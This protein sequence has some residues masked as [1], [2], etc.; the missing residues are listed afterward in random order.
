MRRAPILAEK[1]AR[2]VFAAAL[3]VLCSGCGKPGIPL[4]EVNG[5]VIDAA[6]S[7]PLPGAKVLVA[8]EGEVDV[9]VDSQVVR[10]RQCRTVTGADG[11]FRVAAWRAPRNVIGR[12]KALAFVYLPGYDSRPLDS[13]MDHT[14]AELV[15]HPLY[16]VVTGEPA[17]SHDLDFELERDCA[18]GFVD[19]D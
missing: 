9:L 18:E 14:G 8:W 19:G 10:F 4:P 13:A 11:T 6:T 2:F 12:V 15:T 16:A 3:I 1:G 17:A 5:A 7:R